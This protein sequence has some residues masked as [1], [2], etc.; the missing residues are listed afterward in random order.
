MFLAERLVQSNSLRKTVHIHLVNSF[1]HTKCPRK[2][3]GAIFGTIKRNPGNFLGKFGGPPCKDARGSSLDAL[4]RPDVLRI[5]R[6]THDQ[7]SM[8]G[9][10]V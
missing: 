2:P 3:R 7:D 6:G 4:S 8:A 9:R 10:G 1:H 5:F